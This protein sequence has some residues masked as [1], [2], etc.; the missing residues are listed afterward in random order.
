MS[1]EAAKITLANDDTQ[2]LSPDEIAGK[3]HSAYK[4]AWRMFAKQ[5]ENSIEADKIVP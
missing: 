3:L 5:L 2:G 1:L 4:V